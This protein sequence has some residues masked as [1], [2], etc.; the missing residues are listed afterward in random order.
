VGFKNEFLFQNDINFNDLPTWQRRGTGLYWEKYERAGYNP[1][2]Q[3]A[4]TTVRQRIKVD[5]N[6]PMKEDY[7][8]FIEQLLQLRQS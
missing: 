3:K 7:R 8:E 1:I 4:V 5:E 6:L 2:E